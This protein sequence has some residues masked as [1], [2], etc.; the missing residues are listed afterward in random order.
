[1]T[2]PL[3]ACAVASLARRRK[4]PLPLSR[5]DL[6][7]EG[8]AHGRVANLYYGGDIAAVYPPAYSAETA[9]D[10]APAGLADIGAAL[11][12][13]GS[14]Y[15]GTEIICLMLHEP[16]TAGQHLQILAEHPHRL[17]FGEYYN[18]RADG[19]FV[20][21]V[22]LADGTI[23]RQVAASAYRLH[24]GSFGGLPIK[25]AYGLFGLALA[26]ARHAGMTIY[27]L[28]RRE[29]PRHCSRPGGGIRRGPAHRDSRD[30]RG[31]VGPADRRGKRALF[32]PSS[33][34][35]GRSVSS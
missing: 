7:S 9:E 20:E 18:F 23:G 5:R 17:I 32:A 6:S 22:G 25:L 21:S 28:K 12:Y 2:G 14:H 34:D 33:G 10:N 3:D 29:H 4:A 24:F 30:P 35:P 26:Y 1:M 16:K 15:P 27:F 31:R 8:H 13:A 19:S 11:D